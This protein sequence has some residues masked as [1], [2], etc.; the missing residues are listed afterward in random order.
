MEEESP[1]VIHT[2]WKSSQKDS[3]V[4]SILVLGLSIHDTS[5][6]IMF[7]SCC[8]RKVTADPVASLSYSSL[9]N[10]VGFGVEH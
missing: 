1:K 8:P 2:L 7:L 10:A 4:F 3:P 5:N 9:P 6:A